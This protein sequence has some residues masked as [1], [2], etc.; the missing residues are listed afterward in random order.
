MAQGHVTV[1]GTHHIASAL[2]DIKATLD[3]WKETS[4]GGGIR[5]F[6]RDGDA[7]DEREAAEWQRRRAEREPGGG[8]PGGDLP[9]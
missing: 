2:R 3:G 5:A 4:G 6:A 7:R 9:G 1:Y 8:E